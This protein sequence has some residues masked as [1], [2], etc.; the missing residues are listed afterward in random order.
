M[1]TGFEFS[2]LNRCI[3]FSVYDYW[4]VKITPVIQSWMM[5]RSDE[6]A[7]DLSSPM[8]SLILFYF[9]QFAFTLAP[10]YNVIHIHSHNKNLYF[11]I[12]I[13]IQGSIGVCVKSMSFGQLSSVWFQQRG[14]CFNP[15]VTRF[16]KTQHNDAF[17]EI[18]IFASMNSINLKLCSVVISMLYSKYFSSYK[19]R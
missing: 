13:H 9:H 14:N 8:F 15:Y 2:I 18:Q 3:I 1:P 11:W 19:A 5:F 4:P 10:K 7:L 16:A 6:V 12:W 17:L